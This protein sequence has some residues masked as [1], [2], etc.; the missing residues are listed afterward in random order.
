MTDKLYIKPIEELAPLIKE[1]KISPVELTKEIL[2]QIDTNDEQL[3]AY[4]SVYHEEAIQ[5]AEKAETEIKNGNYRGDLHGI[6]MAIKDNIYIKN[7]T[8]TMGSLIHQDFVPTYDATV[9]KRLR[10]A[11]VI[12]TGKANLHE[13]AMGITT[14]NPHYGIC[15]NPWNLEKGPGGSSGGSGVAVAAS[16]AS[17]SLGTDTA[18]S[19]RI[20]SSAC[21]IV[22]LKPSY[23]RVSRYGAF[24][25]AWSLDHVGPMAKTV[26]DAATI[27]TKMEGFDQKDHA[28]VNVPKINLN[29][30]FTDDIS[31]MVIGINEDFFFKDVDPRIAERTKEAIKA[32]EKLGAKIEVVDIPSLKHAE[33]ALMMTDLSEVTALHHN[34]LLKRPEDFGEDTRQTLE[35]GE[36]M[37]AVDYLQAQ[38][39]RRAIKQDF[40]DV[41]KKVDVLA[42]PTLPILP[43]QIGDKY[44]NLDGKQDELYAVIMRLTGP[45]N[46]A[47]LPAL[48]LPIGSIE[49]LPIGMQM[50]SGV[51]QEEKML[52]AAYA[53]ETAYPLEMT[54]AKL[55]NE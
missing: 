13:Y 49:G 23:G 15:K 10:E 22:G 46:L 42:T 51:F 35:L 25:E 47:G 31:D 53:Y 11:G 33:Y 24:P 52:R 16:M 21:G 9:I 37:S 2:S 36:L 17:A 3:N 40:E 14:E 5:E 4:I 28:S 7:K 44:V 12:F 48:S 41:F 29:K 39:I 1:R 38:Q 54:G 26:K 34:N 30:I 45:C 6:P 43:N 18:G 20:P 27:L 32:F 50:I 19:I 8:T 55:F